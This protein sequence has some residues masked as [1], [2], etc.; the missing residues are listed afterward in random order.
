[1][2]Q[3]CFLFV[4][5]RVS[6]DI[7]D[8]DDKYQGSVAKPRDGAPKKMHPA[9]DPA[10]TFT[11]YPQQPETDGKWQVVGGR[12]R[13]GNDLAPGHSVVGASGASFKCN[14]HNNPIGAVKMTESE[15]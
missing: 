10:P 7:S 6:K 2:L 9:L 1:M 13:R 15:S 3:T 14:Q 11:A 4:F 5:N 8:S 12:R